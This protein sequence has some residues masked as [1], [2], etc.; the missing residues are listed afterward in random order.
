MDAVIIPKGST[1][2]GQPFAHSGLKVIS[3]PVDIIFT[4]YNSFAE[5]YG[6]DFANNSRLCRLVLP[7]GF[8][9]IGS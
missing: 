6:Y 4:E 7:E 9:E 1:L 2:F 8:P 3:L 5:L